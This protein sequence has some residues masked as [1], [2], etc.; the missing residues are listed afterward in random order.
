MQGLVDDSVHQKDLAKK[1]WNESLRKTKRRILP[2]KLTKDT[3][4]GWI[5]TY[6]ISNEETHYATI[7][8]RRL[9][10][11]LGWN[12]TLSLLDNHWLVDGFLCPKCT[13]GIKW[14]ETQRGIVIPA[15]K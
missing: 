1:L 15:G 11:W 7:M 13:G 9:E 10:R 2:Q 8:I 4:V 12:D 6:P 14:L 5:D 3:I